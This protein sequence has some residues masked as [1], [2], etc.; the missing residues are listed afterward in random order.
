MEM[1]TFYS[2]GLTSSLKMTSDEFDSSS[3]D[4]DENPGEE[5]KIQEDILVGFVSNENNDIHY[6]TVLHHIDFN[7]EFEGL[8]S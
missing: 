7:W 3:S 6:E 8:D 5:V 2:P 4:E 1:T